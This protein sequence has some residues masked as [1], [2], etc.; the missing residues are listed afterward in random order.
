MLVRIVDCP[1]EYKEN[2]FLICQ[3]WDIRCDPMRTCENSYVIS[4]KHQHLE[5]IVNFIEKLSLQVKKN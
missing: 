2:L 4:G 5:N 1:E 3:K